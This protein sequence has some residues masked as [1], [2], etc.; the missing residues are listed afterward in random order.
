VGAIEPS[1]LKAEIRRAH[2]KHPES[3]DAYDLYLQ[4]VPHHGAVTLE[5]ND[6]A[7]RLLRD[8]IALDPHFVA[9]KGALVMAATQRVTQG[10]AEPADMAAELRLARSLVEGEADEDPTALARA[11]HTLSFLGQ[12]HEAGLAGSDR[13]L[14][15][16]P[17]SATVLDLS[18]LN[19]L[20]V[21]DWRVATAR[22]ERAMRLSPLDPHM[23][24]RLTS[25]G[26]ACFVGERY[27][28]AAS[29]LR[30]AI[31]HRPRYVVAHR[32]LAAS[33]AA[34]GEHDAARDAVSGLLAAAPGYTVTAAAARTALRGATRER[35]LDGLR[36]AGLPE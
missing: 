23:F 3:L 28:D 2:A 18:G 22:I 25:L 9:A 13:A 7:L 21:D 17:N 4:A 14:R 26:G 34:L 19:R 6:A 32:L 30:Q 24:Y 8:A 12:E 29:W 27:L 36:R 16:A 33:L 35:Y 5:S 20:Y 1:L 31:S 15:L 10:W 11:A